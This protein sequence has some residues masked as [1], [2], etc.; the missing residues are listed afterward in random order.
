MGLPR[1]L[2]VSVMCSELELLGNNIESPLGLSMFRYSPM[3]ELTVGTARITYK[4]EE[5]LKD[6]PRH[7]DL[8]GKPKIFLAKVVLE[9]CGGEESIMLRL[10]SRSQIY[11]AHTQNKLPG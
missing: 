10:P 3:H 6:E 8:S 1:V 5:S 4:L 2:R 7:L 9:I 11:M